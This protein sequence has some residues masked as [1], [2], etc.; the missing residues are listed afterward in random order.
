M[1]LPTKRWYITELAWMPLYRFKWQISIWDLLHGERSVKTC[2]NRTKRV[3]MT[4]SNFL[5]CVLVPTE[6]SKFNKDN[7]PKRAQQKQQQFLSSW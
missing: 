5:S 7:E 2:S 4:L 6:Q 1:S 3:N